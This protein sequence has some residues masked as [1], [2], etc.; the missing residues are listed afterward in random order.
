MTY[1]IQYNV[2][3]MHIVILNLSGTGGKKSSYASQGKRAVPSQ[4]SLD[5]HPPTG[6]ENKYRDSQ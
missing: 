3:A 2:N 4:P 6:D 5:K 1:N